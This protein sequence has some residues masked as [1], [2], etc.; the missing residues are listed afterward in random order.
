L[1]VAKLNSY[2]NI[3]TKI[4]KKQKE[5][6]YYE[7]IAQQVEKLKATKNTLQMKKD[8]ISR[9]ME[10]RLFFP[11]FFEDLLQLLPSN[12]WFKSLETKMMEGQGSNKIQATLDADALDNYSI[13]DLIAA[14]SADSDFRHG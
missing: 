4:Q 3:E 14:L 6:A 11:I 12:V 9:L 10:G 5:L 2:N 13:A 1:Y 8:V 7:S